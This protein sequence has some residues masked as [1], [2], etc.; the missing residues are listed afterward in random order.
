MKHI[1]HNY[2]ISD[3]DWNGIERDEQKQKKKHKKKHETRTNKKYLIVYANTRNFHRNIR[4]FRTISTVI[5]YIRL[6][7]C[8]F[9]H[10]DFL[11]FPNLTQG[12]NWISFITHLIHWC[13]ILFH[14]LIPGIKNTLFFFFFNSHTL[15]SSFVRCTSF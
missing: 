10:S 6:Y 12:K 14:I 3:F 2:W 9:V 13:A 5:L 8:S 7:I 15:F 1:E 4:I 11:I